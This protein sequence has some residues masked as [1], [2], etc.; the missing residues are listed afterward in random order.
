MV[1]LQ[2]IAALRRHSMQLVI[3][4]IREDATRDTKCV[5]ELIIG[6]IH[7][8]DTEYGFQTTFIKR[9]VVSNK[10]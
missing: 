7:L 3:R 6:I 8:I 1:V 10:W 2:Q 5:V 9:L 4:Q